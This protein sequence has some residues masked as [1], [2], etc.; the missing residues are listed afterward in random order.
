MLSIPFSNRKELKPPLQNPVVVSAFWPTAKEP[1]QTRRSLAPATDQT[2][3][4]GSRLTASRAGSFLRNPSA[5]H[6]GL[7]AIHPA[8]VAAAEGQ[9]RVP[10]P[11]LMMAI[12]ARQVRADAE[13]RPGPGCD[14]LKQE[15]RKWG[16]WQGANPAQP[17]SPHSGHA[18]TD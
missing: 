5:S 3:A 11:H 1:P 2:R 4:A 8:R 13:P 16:Y 9:G 15:V 6:L 17:R 10:A 7:L 12:T 14:A 18:R